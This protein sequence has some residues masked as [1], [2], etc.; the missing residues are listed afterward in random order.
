MLV[1]T[2]TI[3]MSG[4]SFN[5][6]PL[7]HQRAESYLNIWRVSPVTI[8]KLINGH[9]PGNSLT[10]REARDL[11]RSWS[12]PVL[13]LVGANPGTPPDILKKLASHGNFEVRTGVAGNANAP[14]DLLLSLRTIGQY[15]TVNHYLAGNAAIP[16]QVLEEMYRNGEAGPVAFAINANLPVQ[17]MAKIAHSE[18][19]L[20]RTHLAAN[21]GLPE[22]LKDLLE[23]DSSE[24]V[25]AYLATNP[26]YA[27]KRRTQGDKVVAEPSDAADSRRKRP[28]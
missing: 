15:T 11:S 18:D 14:L 2:A 3:A 23:K 9:L 25:R 4:C 22:D 28:E 17:I 20:A 21:P 16:Q 1:A 7:Y 26:T 10:E 27:D 5:T 24:S 19:L 8:K 6:P 13:H 12:V